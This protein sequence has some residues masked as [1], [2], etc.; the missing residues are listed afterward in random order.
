MEEEIPR[1][2]GQ[3]KRHESWKKQTGALDK[4]IRGREEGQHEVK[5]E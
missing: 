2:G 3:T 5:G 4:G 1:T